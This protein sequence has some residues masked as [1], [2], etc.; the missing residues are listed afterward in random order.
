MR[1]AFAEGIGWGDAKQALFERIDARSCAVAREIRGV[2]GEAGGDRGDPARRRAAAARAPRDAA[3]GAAA[4]GGRPARPVARVGS[5]RQRR[6]G[7]PRCRCSSSTAR[8]TASSTSSWSTA[9]ACCCR[10]PGS[11]RRA[12]PAS[13]SAALKRD[14]AGSRRADALDHP[15][16]AASARSPRAMPRWPRWRG[17]RR[18]AERCTEPAGDARPR[19]SSARFGAR[20]AVTPRARPARAATAVAQ[21][22]TRRSLTRRTSR[23]RAVIPGRCSRP[24]ARRRRPNTSHCGCRLA[25]CR[26]PDHAAA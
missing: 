16:R 23:V 10:A 12:T 5:R 6:D 26:S 24:I 8:P 3:A 1:A 7:R 18:V 15:R 4:R 22:V 11:M 20:L 21:R 9:N 2:D 13:A 17:R 14:G 25:V 19:G